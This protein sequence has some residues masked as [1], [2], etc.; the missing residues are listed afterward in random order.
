M[1]DR[2]RKDELSKALGVVIK[3]LKQDSNLSARTL[4]Y[5]VNI[6]KTTLLLAEQGRLDPQIST[7][8]K[9]ATLFYK[10]PEELMKLVMSELPENWFKE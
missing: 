3:R 8:C 9:L 5:S 10:T 2:T 4:A 1:Q 6:S 7:F